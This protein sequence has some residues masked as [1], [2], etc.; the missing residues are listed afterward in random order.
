MYLTKSC[1]S[2]FGLCGTP[3]MADLKLSG[4]NNGNSG[5]VLLQAWSEPVTADNCHV[6]YCGLFHG[7][8]V[9]LNYVLLG[10]FLSNN[11]QTN[12]QASKQINK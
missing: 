4:C 8:F 12:K 3:Q 10:T 11:K 1:N 6:A 7:G 2:I 5:Q 9:V